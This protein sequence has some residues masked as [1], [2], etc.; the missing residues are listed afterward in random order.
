MW[1]SGVIETHPQLYG[2]DSACTQPRA[3]PAPHF[4]GAHLHSGSTSQAA[5]LHWQL[6]AM[7]RVWKV[8]AQRTVGRER[9]APSKGCV[10]FTAKNSRDKTRLG[11]RCASSATAPAHRAHRVT[12][13][14]QSPSPRKQTQEG[15]SVTRDLMAS[16]CAGTPQNLQFQSPGFE[17]RDLL[18]RHYVLDTEHWGGRGE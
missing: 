1:V 13:I 6:R 7:G 11:P 17:V 10:I 4:L 12:G 8:P 16:S 14:L 5:L 9:A 2:C 3:F 18:S 15:Q